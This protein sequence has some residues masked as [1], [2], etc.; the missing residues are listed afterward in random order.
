MLNAMADLATRR[1]RTVI[2]SALIA[3]IVAGALGAGVASRLQPYGADDPAT[4]S[5]QADS[6]LEAAG[7][8]DLGVIALLSGVDA[9]SPQ[10]KHRVKALATRISRDPAVGRISDY[11]NTGSRA[12]VSRDLRG[13]LIE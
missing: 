1:S 13:W 11:Y 5:V 10:A 8:Q 3:S 6:R 12:F 4:E 7:F 9:T 2:V